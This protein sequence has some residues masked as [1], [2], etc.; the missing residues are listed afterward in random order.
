MLALVNSTLST[1]SP[2]TLPRLKFHIVSS[3]KA[4]AK[5]ISILLKKRFGKRVEGKIRTYGLNE[6]GDQRL[7]GVKVWAGYR[8]SSLSQVSYSL[9]HNFLDILCFS[10]TNRVRLLSQPIVFARYLIP[11]ML[12]NDVKRVI[13]LDQDVLVKKDLEELWEID[14]EEYPI[15]A[16]RK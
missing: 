2:T 6:I 4:E 1:A 10:L 7:E 13:Y 9:L 14:M 11:S 15:A 3:D 5:T 12:P 8:A 16:A